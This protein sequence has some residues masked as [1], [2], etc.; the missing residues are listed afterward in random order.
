[1]SRHTSAARLVSL[2]RQLPAPDVLKDLLKFQAPAIDRRKARLDA[3]KDLWDLRTIAKRR[4][5]KGPFDYVDGA[6]EKEL[7][8]NRAREAYDNLAFNPQVL[9]NVQKVDL[10]TQLA[11][12]PSAYPLA[13]APTGFTRM[14]HAEG[15]LAGITAAHRF[16]IPFTLS[17]MGT[18]TIEDVAAAGP[19]GRKWFQLYLWQKNRSKA[20]ELIERAAQ[21]GYDT[22]M[23]TV[24]TPVAGARHRDAR[25]GM[26]FPPKLTPATVLNA[27]YR[28]EWWFN[29]L[30]TRPLGFTNFG[31][32]T[33]SIQQIGSMFDPTLTYEDL[34]WLRAQWPGQ[35]LVKG[36]QTAQDAL[37]SVEAG[38]DGVVLSNHGGRQLDR[39]PVPLY[40]LPAVRE[41]IGNEPTVLIDTG[42]MS[43]ADVIAAVALGADGAMIGRAY[44]YGLMAG[45]AEG[46]VRALEIFT[47][48]MT[49][50][51]Q[52][53]GVSKLSDLNSQHVSLDWRVQ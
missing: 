13:I 1:M 8:L 19:D 47:Q 50:T 16:N 24:D 9:K 34:S 4:T 15:E 10:S 52:L 53:L 51:A 22:L 29:F 35:L 38:A 36:V 49:R 12:A 40:T 30:T 26:T 42:I 14:M 43:G 20:S 44:L 6:A 28:P 5:P 21:A 39:A 33:Q 48:E 3:A 2:K 7:S 32:G 25:N 11:G 37:L 31:E 27:S 46:V 23:V 18:E 17:T 41:A 45:G